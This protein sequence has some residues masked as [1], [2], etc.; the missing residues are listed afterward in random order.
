V[1]EY[2]GGR[3]CVCARLDLVQIANVS[4]DHIIVHLSV[5]FGAVS[6][7]DTIVELIVQLADVGHDH[8]IVH[9]SVHLGGIG[10]TDTI[11]QLSVH[12]GVGF[13]RVVDIANQA[14]SLEGLQNL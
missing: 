5:H 13:A 4:H 14:E 12:L 11:V 2:N 1:P 10:G 7:V 9:L 8:I 6:G 3:I